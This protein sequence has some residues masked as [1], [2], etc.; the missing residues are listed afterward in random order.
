L[1]ALAEL[2]DLV[3]DVERLADLLSAV[4][5]YGIWYESVDDLVDQVVAGLR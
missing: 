5:T 2:D 3:A 4:A 1:P